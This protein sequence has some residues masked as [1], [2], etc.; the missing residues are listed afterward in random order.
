MLMDEHPGASERQA[1]NS[2]LLTWNGTRYNLV[3]ASRILGAQLDALRDEPPVLRA[4]A[5][6]D[7]S[8][9]IVPQLSSPLPANTGRRAADNAA[10]I[11]EDERRLAT[12]GLED[13]FILAQGQALANFA[14]LAAAEKSRGTGKPAADAEP[15]RDDADQEP[16]E[17]GHG[18]A[19][20][21]PPPPR[22]RSPPTG[23]GL[24][25]VALITLFV[26]SR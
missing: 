23:G 14:R 18:G 19:A 17:H 24:G 1:H 21:R 4:D 6:A 15:K 20:C 12:A 26:S 10:R 11:E 5:T 22:D 16:Q 7:S 13:P 8:A 25:L 2:L 9:A 3:T